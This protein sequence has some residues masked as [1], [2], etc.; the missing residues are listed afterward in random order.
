M[1]THVSTVPRPRRLVVHSVRQYVQF[2]VT[3]DQEAAAL[4]GET[5]SGLS[6]CLDRISFPG[7][8]RYHVSRAANGTF[9]PLGKV[10]RWMIV[11]RMLGL[12]RSRAQRFVDW[13]QSWVDR[14]W[15]AEDVEQTDDL[16]LR[17]QLADIDEDAAEAAYNAGRP[18]ALDQWIRATECYIA[19]ARCQLVML[20]LRASKAGAP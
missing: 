18:G 1:A 16:Q 20:R 9:N 15:P 19:Q 5:F 2:A 8:T 14:L 4:V 3:A 17:T 13:L 10:V 12:D 7:F 6:G 11:L